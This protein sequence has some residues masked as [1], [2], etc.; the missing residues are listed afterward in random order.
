MCAHFP[1]RVRL[2]DGARHCTAGAVASSFS[3]AKSDRRQ[4]V[5]DGSG[6]RAASRRNRLANPVS[7]APL[8]VV[9]GGGARRPLSDHAWASGSGYRS[10]RG[11]VAR[12]WRL[13][14]DEMVPLRLSIWA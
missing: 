6:H 14:T 3:R 10:L 11:I 4:A 13:F 8:H 2:D 1:P 5:Q 12:G 9:R 7:P